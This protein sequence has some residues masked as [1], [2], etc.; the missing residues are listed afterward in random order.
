MPQHTCL[1]LS[2]TSAF[3]LPDP[4][5]ISI[6]QY[7]ILAYN[8]WQDL[9]ILINLR[10]R[11]VHMRMYIY[12]HII[13]YLTKLHDP[14]IYIKMSSSFV[15]QGTIVFYD[16]E[17]LTTSN[18]ISIWSRATCRSCFIFIITI[19]FLSASIVYTPSR[20]LYFLIYLSS[21][22][23]QLGMVM[24][25]ARSGFAITKPKPAQ[26]LNYQTHPQPA[27]GFNNYQTRNGIRQIFCGFPYLKSQMFNI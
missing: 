18:A 8:G 27:A 14:S 19:S 20:L 21:N 17:R 11:L 15:L 26:N 4:E 2:S 5:R 6:L 9:N 1:R 13:E 10:Q 25:T 16:D 23:P 12:L 22:S 7:C 24:G 3:L